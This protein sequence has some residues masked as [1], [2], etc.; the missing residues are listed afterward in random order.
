MG[1]DGA[2]AKKKVQ[3]KKQR[4]RR[5]RSKTDSSSKN[6]VIKL[7]PTRTQLTE[8][9]NMAQTLPEVMDRGGGSKKNKEDMEEMSTIFTS[10]TQK[11]RSR[12]A[13]IQNHAE[14][15]KRVTG[16]QSL[17]DEQAVDNNVCQDDTERHNVAQGFRHG[18]MMASRITHVQADK[19]TL[20]PQEIITLL[21]AS[22]NVV[23]IERAFQAFHGMSVDRLRLHEPKPEPVLIEVVNK[24]TVFMPKEC[25]KIGR[26]SYWMCMFTTVNHVSGF[27]FLCRADMNRY[28]SSSSQ[29]S[30][31]ACQELTDVMETLDSDIDA[32]VSAVVEHMTTEMTKNKTKT[33]TKTKK[34]KTTAVKAVRKKTKNIKFTQ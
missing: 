3:R 12:K 2:P 31:K 18:C 32:Q 7:K 8:V 15:L 29:E 28:C 4:Q 24:G 22:P 21:K 10:I 20:S 26:R 6:I 16:D 14:Y 27:T 23:D 19:S 13:R 5:R 34:R 11:V 9:F 30:K 25:I 33:K 1:L 17:T